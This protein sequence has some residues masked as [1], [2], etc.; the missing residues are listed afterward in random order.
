MRRGGGEGS[1]GGERPLVEGLQAHD[2]AVKS[3]PDQFSAIQLCASPLEAVR[4][5]DALVIA[6]EWTDYRAVDI[7]E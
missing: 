6:T 1:D 3:M 5:A 2:P 7:Q 4:N